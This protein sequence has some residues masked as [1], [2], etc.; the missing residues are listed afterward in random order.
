MTGDAVD[1]QRALQLGIVSSVVPDGE[2]VDAAL[3]LARKCC[4]ASWL[5]LRLTKQQ[6]RAASDGMSLE[7]AIHAEDKSQVLCLNDQD[8]QA[9]LATKMS[10]FLPKDAKL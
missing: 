5:G 9:F 4:R 7:Q 2:V 3:A 10:K 8:T 1:A 6:L